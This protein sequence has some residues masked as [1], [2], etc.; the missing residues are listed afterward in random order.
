MR[1]NLT[2]T[3]LVCEDLARQE[4]V[5]K[6]IRSVAPDLVI[7]LLMDASQIKERWPGRYATVLSEDPGCSVF[8]F[9]SYG[10]V[11]QSSE[12][13]FDRLGLKAQEKTD[14]MKELAVGLW[15]NAGSPDATSICMGPD[16]AAVLIKLRMDFRGEWSL[17]SR[18]NKTSYWELN[19]SSIRKLPK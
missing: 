4:P 13:Y 3:V 15:R 18:E 5:G 6:V 1:N 9:S 14:K 19:T 2:A 11:K 17:D 10:M 16:D 7:A 8:T 12:V